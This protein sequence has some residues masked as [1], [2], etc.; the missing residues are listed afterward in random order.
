LSRTI[1]V[2]HKK[3]EHVGS[4]QMW[5]FDSH[6]VYIAVNYTCVPALARSLIA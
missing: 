4:V 3:T 6:F 1:F 2:G 5:W